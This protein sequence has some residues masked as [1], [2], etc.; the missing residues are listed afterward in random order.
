MNRGSWMQQY[1]H[2]LELSYQAKQR[3]LLFMEP[4]LSR[5]G[6]GRVDRLTRPVEELT[7]RAL[8][9]CRMCG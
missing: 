4:L 3:L 5:L 9:E 2:F 8:F 6:F 7:K 1:P